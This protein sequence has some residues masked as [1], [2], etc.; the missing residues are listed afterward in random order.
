MKKIQE[1]CAA[2]MLLFVLSLSALAG[3]IHTNAVEPPP[4]P[5]ASATATQPDDGTT[6]GIQSAADYDTLLA[7]ITMSVLQLLSV[8]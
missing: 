8:V 5:P 4:P 1:L 7:E 2:T 6:D 3:E